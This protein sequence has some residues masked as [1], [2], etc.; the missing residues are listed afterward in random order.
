MLPFESKIFSSELG[1]LGEEFEVQLSGRSRRGKNSKPLFRMRLGRSKLF[2][3][4]K[5]EINSTD[6][7][8]IF[9]ENSST[10]KSLEERTQSS[11]GVA[12]AE[13]VSLKAPPREKSDN[14]SPFGDTGN[15]GISPNDVSPVFKRPF[16]KSLSMAEKVEKPPPISEVIG[17]R[18]TGSDVS[19]VSN[20]SDLSVTRDHPLEFSLASGIREG[21]SPYMVG[22]T[23]DLMGRR[24]SD[25]LKQVYDRRATTDVYGLPK[26]L[27]LLTDPRRKIFEIVPIPYHPQETTVGEILNQ[28]PRIATDHRLKYQMYTGIAFRGVHIRPSLVPTGAIEDGAARRLP[29]LAIPRNYTATQMGDIATNLFQSPAVL[30]LLEEQLVELETGSKQKVDN[31]YFATNEEEYPPKVYSS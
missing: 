20:V 14:S 27:I 21:G 9:E 6:E 8:M 22:L 3:K 26:C 2:E 1:S 31:A 13:V 4:E 10:D 24:K 23:E 12:S 29:L 18:R 25:F 15:K 17:L 16:G 7:C 19:D 30:R 11:L 5:F 28:I